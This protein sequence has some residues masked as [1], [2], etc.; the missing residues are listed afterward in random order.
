MKAS[1]LHGVKDLRY[2]DFPDP[3]INDD[4][5]LLKV[6]A[7]GICGSDLPR[8]FSTGSYDMPKILGHE[9][10]GQIVQCGANVKGYKPGDRAAAIPLMPCGK[11]TYCNIG[12]Y[13]HCG[14]YSFLGSRAHGG[15]A[16]LVA[17]PQKN[18]VLL[19][20]SVSDVAGAMFE[21]IAVAEHC[22]KQVQVHPGER[23][24]VFGAGAIGIFIAQWAKVAGAGKVWIVDIR[25]TAL[26]IAAKCGLTDGL[27]ASKIDV[28]K[29]VEEA[30]CGIGADVAI[31]AAGAQASTIASF[32]IAR[33]RGR[34]A[35]IGR[36][37][38]DLILSPPDLEAILRR[39]LTIKGCWGFEAIDFP[40]NDWA[41]AAEALAQ[42]KII[43]EPLITHTYPLS[44]TLDAV[45]M[46]GA[47]KEYFCKVILEIN[48]TKRSK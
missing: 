21:P 26:D 14:Q 28:V 24:V 35:L 33:K 8:Y 29:H 23:V 47:K 17:V 18:L 41:I 44:K 13:F 31:E 25:P 9:F 39:E 2:E 36:M 20:D 10:M 15:W 3:Q 27:D 22:I 42:G 45:E 6:G 12:M 5:V 1:V 38:N 37:V 46:M 4:Q 16:E 19:E 7:C 11:C 34:V 40:R 30:T 32:K 48:P 43:A